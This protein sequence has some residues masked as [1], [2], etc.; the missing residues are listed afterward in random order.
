MRSFN[1]S[2]PY[3]R[4]FCPIATIR[5]M[6]RLI[7]V[8]IVLLSSSAQPSIASEEDSVTSDSVSFGASFPA[9]GVASPGVASYYSGINAYFSYVNDNGGV[10]GRKINFI[11]KDDGNLPGRAIAGNNELILAN[12]VLALIST[13]PSCATQV[14]VN[15]NA[16]LGAKGI[17][18]LFVD[19]LID[20]SSEDS[21]QTSP[22]RTSTSYYGKISSQ[23]QITLLKSYIDKAFPNQKI[24]L[25]YQDDDNSIGISK[26]KTDSKVLCSK[27]FIA[28]LA[29]QTLGS[30]VSLC[31]TNGDL[32]DGDL[33][34]YA[35]SPTGLGSLISQFLNAK[36]NLKYFVN[37]DA[38][39]PTALA[40]MG[41]RSNLMP[42]IY[43]LSSNALIS[44]TSNDAIKTFLAFGQKYR[45]NSTLDQQ[46]INGLNVGYIVS[47]LLGAV[48]PDLTR[49]RLMK[50]M[51]LYGAQFDAL[52]L[53]ERS[54]D[55]A[56]RFMPLGGVIVKNSGTSSEAVSDVLTLENGNVSTKP[57]KQIPVSPK[58]L[59]ILVQKLPSSV[60][61]PKASTPSAAP[62][63]RKTV[64]PAP[65]PS[66]ISELDGE[67]ELP[68]GKISVK[69]EKNKYLI[70]ISSNLPNENLQVRA[71]KKGQR[72]ISFKV[73][74][75]D[76]GFA[77]FNT[78][79]SLSGF[80]VALLLDGEILNS[81]RA[82]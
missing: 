61:A 52:G 53:S 15:S 37:S 7:F 17:P 78:S 51:D 32:K 50:A 55:P 57:R 79:R 73:S 34:F 9:T 35:G 6:K 63:P 20:K 19:C 46:F 49:E 18:N 71:T 14:A 27:S 8:L 64:S 75:D 12:N 41:I 74:T 1:L 76:D 70:S 31:K 62:E 82:S 30:V 80:Q 13:A 77:K 65:E 47:N 60:P 48:G 4:D 40:A 58:G 24:V 29:A 5:P 26:I 11:R 2:S 28:G 67:E 66:P 42:E 21:E 3:A 81:V 43:T 36:L 25:V 44:E 56:T 54:Q 38:F 10:Y 72:S 69:K 45:G 22:S 59:P 33:V 39:N 16:N 23:N 68:F